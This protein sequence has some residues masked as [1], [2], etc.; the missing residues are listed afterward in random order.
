MYICSH[1]TSVGICSEMA[2]T[3]YFSFYDS[4]KDNWEV[5][6]EVIYEETLIICSCWCEE[7]RKFHSGLAVVNLWWEGSNETSF[8]QETNHR[9][10]SF[11]DCFSKINTTWCF[12]TGRPHLASRFLDLWPGHKLNTGPP[13]HIMKCKCCV[14]I[15]VWEQKREGVCW[16]CCF[17]YVGRVK[18]WFPLS[19]LVSGGFV[20]SACRE[21]W[22]G[23]L[24]FGLNQ[25]VLFETLI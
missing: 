6:P 22:V 19:L 11:P 15:S 5:L 14:F 17:L 12:F 10:T 25:Q 21:N 9:G 24:P 8:R 23:F 4:N 20:I 3:R 1:M 13:L 2:V 16:V 18:L 7:L